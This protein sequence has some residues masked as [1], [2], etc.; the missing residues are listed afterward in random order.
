MF[1]TGDLI[2]YGNSGV[3]KVAQVGTPNVKAF[4]QTKLYYTLQ[5]LYSTETIYTPV[6]TDVFMRPVISRSQAEE[7]I[8]QIPS[9]REVVCKDRN[10]SLIHI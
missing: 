4:D 7:L 2:I 10:L 8:H 6:D 3:C 1:E 5:P 9:I